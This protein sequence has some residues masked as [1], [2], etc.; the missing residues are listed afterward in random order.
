[1]SRAENRAGKKGGLRTCPLVGVIA[2]VTAKR[3]E[4]RARATWVGV[5]NGMFLCGHDRAVRVLTGL[6]DGYPYEPPGG[7]DVDSQCNARVRDI[8]LLLHCLVAPFTNIVI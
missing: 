1:M 2:V 7:Y 3:D 8:L 4:N 6:V 5:R